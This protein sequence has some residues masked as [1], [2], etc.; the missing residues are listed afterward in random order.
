[1]GELFLKI[2]LKSVDLIV[3]VLSHL[4]KQATATYDYKQAK[5][6]TNHQQ[7]TAGQQ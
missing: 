1:M 4:R 6:I 2:K 7:T 3:R 5:T